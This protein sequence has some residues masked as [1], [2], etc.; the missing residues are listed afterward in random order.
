MCPL[1]FQPRGTW[2]P[3]R[4]PTELP[5]TPG[6]SREFLDKGSGQQKLMKGRDGAGLYGPPWGWCDS[7][8]GVCPL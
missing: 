3:Q 7:P 6:C 1:L 2:S 8:E 4:L 5:T